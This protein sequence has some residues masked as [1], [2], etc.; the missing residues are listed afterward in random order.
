[1]AG[2]TGIVEGLAGEVEEGYADGLV[3]GGAGRQVTG[4]VVRA[5]DCGVGGGDVGGG[6]G[7]GGGLLEAETGD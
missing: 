5:G 2:D 7:A 6:G 1:M 4:E 3:A